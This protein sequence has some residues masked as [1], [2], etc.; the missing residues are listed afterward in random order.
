MN[1]LIW[2]EGSAKT[3][4]GHL[5]RC[6]M[7]ARALRERCGACSVLLTGAPGE[8]LLPFRESFD[9]VQKTPPG[10]EPGSAFQMMIGLAKRNS[11]TLIVMDKPEYP[12]A[13]CHLLKQFKIKHRH[14]AFVAFGAAEMPPNCVDMIIDANRDKSDA[15]KFDGSITLALFGPKYA[16]L[17]PDFAKA[18][19]RFSVR[20]SFERL[21]I[22]MGGSDPNFVTLIAYQVAVRLEGPMIDI[23]LGPAFSDDYWNRLEPDIDKTRTTIHRDIGHKELAELFARADGCI[24]SGGI[25]MFDAAAVGLPTII[26]SQNEPQLSNAKRLAS[27]SAVVNAGLFS[28]TSAE[29]IASILADWQSS[30]DVRAELSRRASETVDGKGVERVC[31]AISHLLAS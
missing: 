10:S 23:V 11:I 3:G 31:A 4:L 21:V 2:A 9:S 30:R 15:G 24:V 20:D 27:H 6:A 12:A 7:L 19:K 17:A 25:T 5:S 1:C 14:P 8:V 13:F 18:R 16:A 22:S 26:V 28:Q 29:D